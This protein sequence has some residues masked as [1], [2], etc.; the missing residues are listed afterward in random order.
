MCF[1]CFVVESLLAKQ[2][3]SA[4]TRVALNRPTGTG[5][6]TCWGGVFDAGPR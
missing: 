1:L 2:E 3:V 5:Q 6:V 4:H